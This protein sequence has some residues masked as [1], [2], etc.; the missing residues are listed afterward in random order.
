MARTSTPV[1]SR[2]MRGSRLAARG[3][4]LVARGSEYRVLLWLV[5]QNTG[6]VVARGSEYMD[7]RGSWLRIY[8]LSWLVAQNIGIVV[9]R[10]SS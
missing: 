1:A 7:C 8:G 2:L 9:A 5:A 6:I 4:R 3:S 10:G